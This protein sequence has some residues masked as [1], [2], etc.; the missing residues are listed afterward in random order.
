MHA[1]QPLI[2]NE[3][4]VAAMM[5]ARAGTERQAFQN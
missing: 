1:V 2:P 5:E 4:T 3:V